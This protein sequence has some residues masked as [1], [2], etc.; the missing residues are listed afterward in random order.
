M[1]QTMLFRKVAIT[2]TYDQFF[3]V[4]L[5]FGTD[6]QKTRAEL[7]AAL[8]LSSGQ[9][10]RIF[11]DGRLL[12]LWDQQ[13]RLQTPGQH[14][15]SDLRQFRRVR[16]ETIREAAQHVPLFA[17]ALK[18]LAG[19]DDPEEIFHYFR[20][21]TG[22]TARPQEVGCARRRYLEAFFPKTLPRALPLTE[23]RAT[24]QQLPFLVETFGDEAAL[25]MPRMGRLVA[26]YLHLRRDFSAEEIAACQRLESQLTKR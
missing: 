10:S 26:G 22:T 20:E 4:L 12:K 9:A 24:Q 14:W 25:T 15:R 8:N 1:E 23:K 17:Q 11:R 13:Q 5:E 21:R 3:P 6:D 18:D 7:C 19:V 16:P 2:T